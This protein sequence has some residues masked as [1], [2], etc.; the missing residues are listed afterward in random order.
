[1]KNNL[2]LQ[3]IR[4]AERNSHIEIYSGK[5]LYESGSWLQKPIRT[6]LDLMPLFR[7]YRELHIL[8][9]GGGVGRNSIP[10]AQEYRNISCTVECVDILEL[11]IEKLKDNAQKYNAA[12]TIKG[13]VSSIE[14][15]AIEENN[16]DL[17]MA[18]SA[19]EHVESKDAF[20]H[21][22]IE[23]RDGIRE[24]GIV[25]LVINSEVIETDKQTGESLPPQFEVNLSTDEM[26][27]I[28]M[29]TFCDWNIIKR[30]VRAQQYDIPRECGV[31]ELKTNVVTLVARKV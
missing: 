21:K 2:R 26:Q 28:L 4:E 15:Y 9:L 30:T 31:V 22:L 19:L 23:M 13:I 12:S 7:D 27:K 3:Q 20:I 29:D 18:I 10:F 5:E 17:I 25:C 24:N 14:D 6:V 1:M 16:Y 8:D 11:A